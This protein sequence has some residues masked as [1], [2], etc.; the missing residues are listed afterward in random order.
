[1]NWTIHNDLEEWKEDDFQVLDK[2]HF[3]ISTMHEPWVINE[4]RLSNLKQFLTYSPPIYHR[5]E[6]NQSQSMMPMTTMNKRKRMISKFISG[7]LTYVC[8]DYLYTIPPFNITVTAVFRISQFRTSKSK[9]TTSAC[10]D[11]K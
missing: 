2:H 5:L 6:L 1:M 11:Q 10:R 3:T 9:S 8:I 4:K 7:Y